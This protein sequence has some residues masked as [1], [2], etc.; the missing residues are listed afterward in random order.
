[1]VDAGWV[2]STCWS[3]IQGWVDPR[4]AAKIKFITMAELT[5]YISKENLP[6]EYGGNWEISS[7][8]ESSK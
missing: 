3:I 1:M 2:F 7:N 5:E 6:K 8:T 4:T